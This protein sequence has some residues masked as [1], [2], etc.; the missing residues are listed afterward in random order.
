VS[1]RGNSA[2]DVYA[3]LGGPDD[4]HADAWKNLQPGQSYETVPVA[5]GCVKGDFTDAVDALTIY[6]RLACKRSRKDGDRCPVIFNDYMN[7]LWGDPT[8]AKELPMIEAAASAG[9][10]YYVIDAG[11]Y[12][13]LNEDWSQT[14]GAWEPSQTRWSHGLKYVLD[15]IRDSG[16][17]PGLWLEPEV[18]GARST[19]ASKPDDWFFMRHGKRVLK[20]SRYLLDFRNPDVRSYLDQVIERVVHDYGVGYI[21]MDYNTDSLLG[22]DLHADSVGQ[23][24]LEHD[25]AYLVWIDR[26][27]ERYPDLIL[28]NCGS[29]GGRMDYAQL[30]RFQIQSVTDQEDYLRMPAILTGASAGILPEQAAI[31]SYPTANGES[32]SASFNMVTGMV[33]RIHQSGRLDE[34]SSDAFQQVRTGI[35]LYKNILRKHV[36][37]AVPFYPLGMPDVTDSNSPISLGMRAPELTW[38][39]VWRLDGPS[40]VTIP[41]VSKQPRI[42]FPTELGINLTQEEHQ[43]VVDFPRTRMGCLLLT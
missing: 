9:C 31:W 17:T 32:D 24:L 34:I 14:T 2:N 37:K 16:M 28:E 33:C 41:I 15:K 4:L 26:I 35:E 18:A 19:L 43:L 42:L 13:E 39:A 12:A 22:T 20:N 27:L 10:E 11:W 8:E 38:I 23:G 5:I 29:G 40:R 1:A 3:Y 30:S 36:P 6:R 25:R 7:C 21:K